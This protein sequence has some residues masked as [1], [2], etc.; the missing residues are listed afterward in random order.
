[1]ER[2]ECIMCILYVTDP[3][4][5]LRKAGGQFVVCREQ[6]VLARIPLEKLEGV[7]LFGGVQASAQVLT[8]L[9]QRGVSTLWLSRKGGYYGRLQPALQQDDAACQRK[10]FLLSADGPWRLELAKNLVDAKLHNSITLVRR[11]ARKLSQ[12]LLVKAAEEMQRLREKAAQASSL[13]TLLGIEGSAARV[14]FQGFPKMLP[15]G[16]AFAGRSRRPPRDPVNSLLSF[17]YF[18]VLQELHSFLA[19]RGL[20]P[21]V[22][23]LHKE[24]KGHPALAS[25][26]LEEWRP[27]LVDSLVLS[28]LW[29]NRLREEHFLPPD[30]RGGVY[31]REDGRRLFLNAYEERLNRESGYGGRTISYREALRQ[32]VLALHRAVLE[33]KT[34]YYKAFVIR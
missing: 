3:A 25:D 26:L 27:V 30:A 10:Q 20:Q 22:G 24:R 34:A 16:F 14:Y 17:G 7:V 15:G 23:F 18:L 12:P 9:L 1:M 33:E 31:L 6:D 11:Y 32:Q 8:T 2:E 5:Q 21:Y 13:E 19:Q 29:G 28:L 4:A